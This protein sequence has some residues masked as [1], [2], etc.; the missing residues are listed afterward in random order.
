MRPTRCA[1][2]RRISS[3]NCTYR[4]VRAAAKGAGGS[5]RGGNSAA[6]R[7]P[8]GVPGTLPFRGAESS[9][10]RRTRPGH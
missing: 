9:F 1:R 2:E 6:K 7:P 3:N 10:R 5:R 4:T 8:R